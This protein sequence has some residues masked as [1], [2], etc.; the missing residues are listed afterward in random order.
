MHKT[1]DFFLSNHDDWSNMKPSFIT[2]TVIHADVVLRDG[3]ISSRKT[4]LKIETNFDVISL[5]KWTHL[6]FTLY[7]YYSESSC[8]SFFSSLQVCASWT[9]SFLLIIAFSVLSY[10]SGALN[11]WQ[12]SFGSEQHKHTERKGKKVEIFECWFV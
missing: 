3:F 5:C 2:R 8:A 1:Q 12:R 6:V 10:M 11:A 4:E 9:V 7:D